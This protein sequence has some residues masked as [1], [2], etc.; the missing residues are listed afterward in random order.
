MKKTLFISALCA[1]VLCSCSKS[2]DEEDSSS[3]SRAEIHFDLAGQ[4]FQGQPSDNILEYFSFN[5]TGTDFNGG[6][7][8]QELT[9]SS[10][11]AVIVCSQ[12]PSEN[13]SFYAQL[14]LDVKA[15]KQ[16]PEGTYPINYS[17]HVH[18]IIYGKD[19]K[20]I[21]KGF[22]TRTTYRNDYASANDF[23]DEM[24]GNS[25]MGDFEL[26]YTKMLLSDEWDYS[27]AYSKKMS[28]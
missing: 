14:G 25:F 13:K 27:I 26:C 6:K 23:E 21:S 19:G 3:F 12:A 5:V 24:T 7:V 11:S 8:S 1:L 10:P 28:N 9:M 17:I 18:Y 15:R 16:I 20:E 22:I 4:D 2:S